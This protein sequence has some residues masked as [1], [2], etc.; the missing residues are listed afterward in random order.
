M[1]V[2]AKLQLGPG[3]RV[4]LVG[5]PPGLDLDLDPADVADHPAGADAVILFV[6]TAAE[7]AETSEPAVTAARHDT[8][9]WIAYPKGGQLG[10]DLSRDSLA[11]ALAG[12]GVRP[13]RQVSIDDVWSALRFR[14]DR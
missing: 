6:R 13:V 9:A 12:Y 7:L 4:A 11:A 8:L 3:R 1:A 14:P 5:A 2:A 10:T